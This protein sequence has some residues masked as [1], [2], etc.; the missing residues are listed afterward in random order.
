MNC[1]ASFNDI[2]NALLVRHQRESSSQEPVSR[3][4]GV[5]NDI[6][7]I[8]N[9]RLDIILGLSSLD[10][11]TEP[12]ILVADQ[13]RGVWNLVFKTFYLDSNGGEERNLQ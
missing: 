7:D 4:I 5:D 8:M 13:L 10:T 6:E 12:L 3:V 2:W 1:C 9:T 11:G